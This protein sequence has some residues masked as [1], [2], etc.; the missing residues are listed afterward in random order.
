[1]SV[2]NIQRKCKMLYFQ[3]YLKSMIIIRNII[4]FYADITNGD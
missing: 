3:T 1:M 2:G 4:Q